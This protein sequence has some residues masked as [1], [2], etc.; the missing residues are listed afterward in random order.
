[1]QKLIGVICLVVALWLWFQGHNVA[2]SIGSQFSQA[3]TGAPMGKATH[4]YAAG[5][6]LGLFGGFLIFWKR[7]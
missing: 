3:F 5:V 6:V 2:N 1:M 4:Y 7:K